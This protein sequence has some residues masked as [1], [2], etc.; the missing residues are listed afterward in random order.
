MQ[1]TIL[2]VLFIC[3]G[4]TAQ[5]TKQTVEALLEKSGS[6]TMFKDMDSMI[7]AQIAGRKATFEKEADFEKFSNTMRSGFNGT[8]AEG[9][10]IEY[11]TKYANEDSL[12][13]I[14]RLYE[15]PLMQEMTALEKEV[16]APS[17]QQEMQS[18]MAGLSSNPPSA[19]RRELMK[20]IDKATGASDMFVQLIKNMAFSM[21]RGANQALPVEKQQDTTELNNMLKNAFPESVKEQMANQLMSMWL[22]SYKDVDNDKLN[23]YIQIWESAEGK[24]NSKL[25]VSALDYTFSKIGEDFGKVLGTFAK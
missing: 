20:R 12:K 16:G 25:R 15:L 21:A 7:E 24:Y 19:E 18:F 1:I 13:S 22:F 5:S 17:K 4:A 3:L 9:Y 14:I 10:F 11:F 6:M 2:S 8:K 23:K